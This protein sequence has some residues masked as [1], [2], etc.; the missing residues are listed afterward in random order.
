MN[1]LPIATGDPDEY[2]GFTKFAYD[3]GFKA[4][5]PNKGLGIKYFLFVFRLSYYFQG[6]RDHLEIYIEDNPE[7]KYN[8]GFMENAKALGLPRD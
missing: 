7:L 6:F 8:T 5:E 1:N 4:C 3:S 2:K